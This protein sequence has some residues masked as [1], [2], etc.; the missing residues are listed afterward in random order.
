[1]K[2]GECMEESDEKN[3]VEEQSTSA[4]EAVD[5]DEKDIMEDD[6]DTSDDWNAQYREAPSIGRYWFVIVPAV[7]AGLMLA[8][9]Y[10]FSVITA[11]PFWNALLKS[12]DLYLLIGMLIA[13]ICLLVENNSRKY[14]RGHMW[15]YFVVQ[16]AAFAGTFSAS[17]M[18]F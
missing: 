13:L 3:N 10:Q 4:E 1:M 18:R 15:I 6:E 11:Q 5:D 2:K 8:F 17:L 9:A 7:L 14:S 16:A 12:A